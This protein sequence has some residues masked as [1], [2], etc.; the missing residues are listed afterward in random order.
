MNE[1]EARYAYPQCIGSELIFLMETRLVQPSARL[2]S[3]LDKNGD[4]EGVK[5]GPGTYPLL[6]YTGG[7]NIHV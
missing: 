4:K 7:I 1:K 6:P 2:A 3:L 5:K